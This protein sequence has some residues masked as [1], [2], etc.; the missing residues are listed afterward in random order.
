MQ[1]VVFFALLY[2]GLSCATLLRAD[3]VT[4][5]S[6]VI[7]FGSMT[8]TN[9]ALVR[10][11][12]DHYTLRR[13]YPAEEFK[14]R[15]DV[16]EY[17]LDHMEVCSALAQ[18][19]GLIEYRATRGADGRIQ[20]DDHAGATG[21]MLDVYAG[22]GKRII[23]VEGVGHGLFNVRGRGVAI[24]EY[25]AKADDAI[26]YA[27]TAFVK[28]DN[29]VL[30][31]LAQLFSVFLHGTVDSHFTHVIR[32]PVV[33]SERAQADPQKLVD[34][35]GQMPDADQQ[36]LAPLVALVRSNTAARLSGGNHSH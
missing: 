3:D 35:I 10:G 25:H 5:A 7:P 16:F 15:V 2:L 9:R 24:V 1:R 20:A 17:L 11:V 6:R 22:A 13:E 36:L 27:R 23:Y 18:Q 21:Y 14:A 26:E 30:A 12:T 8:L 19:A 32:N 29:A 31:A 4:A 34:Q 28:V 33:L